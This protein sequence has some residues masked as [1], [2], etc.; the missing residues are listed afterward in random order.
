MPTEPEQL[1]EGFV[2]VRPDDKEKQTLVQ[3][4]ARKG[5]ILFADQQ[6]SPI[7]LLLTATIR[8]TARSRLIRPD[9]P[10]GRKTD[11]SEVCRRVYYTCCE[12]DY[13]RQI[14]FNRLADSLFGNNA[15]A[16]KPAIHTTFVAIDTADRLPYFTVTEKTLWNAHR[17]LLG[18]FVGRNAAGVYARLCNEAFGLCREPDLG[19]SKK[20]A[21]CPYYQMGICPAL[22]GQETLPEAYRKAIEDGLV[23]LHSGLQPL[24]DRQTVQMRDCAGRLEFEKA[25]RLRQVIEW[26]T[27]LQSEKYRWICRLDRLELLHIDR[28]HTGRKQEPQYCG[29]WITGSASVELTP[30]TSAQ[31]PQMLEQAAA[32]RHNPPQAKIA[33]AAIREHLG[34]VPLMLYRNRMPGLWFD[35]CRQPLP[36]ADQI[37]QMLAGYFY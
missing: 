17:R 32:L 9:K 2:D 34:I 20:F 35:L 18:P 25:Q 14:E 13:A 15:K 33:P 31:I 28:L 1:F 27:E 11:V 3:L 12:C 24:I 6:D 30:F 23:A 26:L 37:E 29:F 19:K 36:T 4:P 7:Q 21:Q 10:A 8:Q 22:C 16:H 5:L